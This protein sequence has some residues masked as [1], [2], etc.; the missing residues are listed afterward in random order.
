MERILGFI[1]RDEEAGQRADQILN[2]RFAMSRAMRKRIRQNPQGLMVNGQP[3]F[4]SARLA[5]GDRVELMLETAEAH[6][7][8]ILPQ[9]GRVDIVYEDEDLLVLEK[10][11]GIPTEPGAGPVA[12]SLAGRVIGHYQRQGDNVV[13]RAVNR[14][15]R[16]T[17]GLLV[18]AKNAWIH[19]SLQ[20]QMISGRFVRE[21]R[22]IVAV[23]PYP[24]SG[25]IAAPIRR[26]PGSIL[27]RE[28]HPEG[29]TAKTFYS[30]LCY[31]GEFTLL[32]ISTESGRTHQIRVHLASI[33]CPLVGD[34]LYGQ[35]QPEWMDRPAL[36]ASGL[37]FIHPLSGQG[38]EFSSKLPQDF[39]RLLQ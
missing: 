37:S 17:S 39:Q 23:Q 24:E 12:D 22:A 27:E 1:I 13:F 32:G 34:F 3:F 20:Q 29:A 18:V 26:K 15:D 16:G 4:M 6:S 19:E 25:L 7:S 38:L 33:G 31:R 5:A 21:Y 8:N 28:V 30:C 11:A 10:S 36:H 9:N 35:E 14:L 2:R